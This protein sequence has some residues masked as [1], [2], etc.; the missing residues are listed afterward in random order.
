MTNRIVNVLESTGLPVFLHGSLNPDEGYPNT[1]L[2]FWNFDAPEGQ[3]YDNEAH[4]AM[5]GFTVR[6]YSND[7]RTV[8]TETEE[9]RKLLKKDGFIIQGRGI[10]SDSGRITHTGKMLTVYYME[11]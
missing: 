10:D 4:S 6:I 5:W 8:E 2:T 1:F 11:V 9:V 7:P 3:F